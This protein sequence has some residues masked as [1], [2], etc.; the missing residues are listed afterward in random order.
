MSTSCLVGA[1]GIERMRIEEFQ[2]VTRNVGESKVMKR[3]GRK[4]NC[5]P[6]V[7]SFLIACRPET[8]R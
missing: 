7:P 2:G 1:V 6:I 4:F 5:S 3:K 8:P